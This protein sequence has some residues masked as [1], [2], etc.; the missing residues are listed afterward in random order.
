MSTKKGSVIALFCIAL[1]ALS[2]IL[3]LIGD[4]NITSPSSLGTV[5]LNIETY[6]AGE[7]QPTHPSVYIFDEPWNGYKY[8][9]AYS[10]YPEGN[11]EEEN[12]CIAV[13][14]DLYYWETPGTLANPIATNEETVCNELKD[15]HI[16]YREDLDRIEI[17][18]LGRLSERLGGDGTSL[19]LMRK[20][21]TDGVTWS[22]YE[23]MSETQYLSPSVIWNGKNYQMWSI[24]YDLFDNTGTISYQESVD[25]HSWTDPILCTVGTENTNIDI[26]HGSVTE[27][28]GVF[29]MS[30]IDNTDK[31]E[32]FYCISNDG[33]NFD[34]P[35]MIISNDGFWRNLYRPFLWFDGESYTCIYGVV[36]AANQWYLSMSSGDAADSLHGITSADCSRMY[37]LTD[38]ITDTHSLGFKLGKLYDTVKGYLRIELLALAVLEIL[39]MVLVPRLSASMMYFIICLIGNLIVSFFWIVIRMQLSGTYYLGAAIISIIILNCSIAAMVRCAQFHLN[40][41]I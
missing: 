41:N 1:T 35:E 37:P 21:S 31:Q 38:H 20:Y 13:S 8:W 39:V 5:R 25:G 6:L 4:I 36:N 9:L 24:G 19:L 15:P 10:P 29:Y 34:E 26:W 12:P 7:N 17:W 23:V 11:G 40:K 28:N 27:H 33:V 2:L 22:E 30:Y 18:Y 14:N 16:V 32:I 3:F